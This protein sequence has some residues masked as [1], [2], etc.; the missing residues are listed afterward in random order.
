MR[1]KWFNFASERGEIGPLLLEAYSRV[2]DRG[3]FIRGPEVQAFEHEYAAFCGACHCVGVG[4][5]LDAL[6]LALR[7]VGVGPGDEVIVPAHTFVATWL[8]VTYAGATPVPVDV[9]AETANLD[10]ERLQQAITP[11]TKAVVPVDL[12]GRPAELDPVREVAAAH[13]LRV[14]EDAAQSHGAVYHGKRV[15]SIADVTAF[16]FYPVKN[17]G[18]LGDG[19]AVTTNDADIAET[20]RRL[21]NYGSSQKYMHEVRGFNSRLDE[22][23]AAFLRVKLSRLEEWNAR[24]RRMAATYLRELAGKGLSL[25][26]DDPSHVWH[27]FA[28]SHDSRDRIREALSRAGIDT[29]VHYPVPPHRQPAYVSLGFGAGSFPVA[30]TWARTE[31][32][33]P[34]SAFHTDAEQAYVI[35]EL[36]R[37]VP[38]LS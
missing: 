8:A 31:L 17:L 21:G 28:I 12:Y 22:L 6:H 10:P 4:N 25:P 37:V 24:R 34:I 5:G 2:M 19:G 26:V 16:S 11:R 30:E 15:G 9:G 7:A 3:E 33:L 38:G 20:V 1:V 29:I 13:G 32:S 27:L 23:Q 35:E 36:T 14:V 18:A